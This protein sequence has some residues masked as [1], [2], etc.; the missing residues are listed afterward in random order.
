MR[1]RVIFADSTVEL[2][3]HDAPAAERACLH[4][5]RAAAFARQLQHSGVRVRVAQVD[6]VD[7]I[8]QPRLL[9]LLKG[10]GDAQIVRL[11]AEQSRD[12]RTVGAVALSR[13]GKRAV[14]VELRVRDLLTEQRARHRADAGSARRV[15]AG[16]P[17]HHG[18]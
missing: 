4:G 7:G 6:L 15:R 5:Q 10:V 11:H 2:I 16:R 17:D 13:F 14:K 1:M 18:A 3:D 8:A 9:R 12:E